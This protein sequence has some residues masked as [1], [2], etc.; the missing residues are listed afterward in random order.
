MNEDEKLLRKANKAWRQIYAIKSIELGFA[1]ASLI[2][3]KEQTGYNYNSSSHD[4]EEK[5]YLVGSELPTNL[6]VF[7]ISNDYSLRQDIRIPVVGRKSP[8]GLKEF[9]GSD[10][11]A[12]GLS[13]GGYYYSNLKERMKVITSST[14]Q[15]PQEWIDGDCDDILFAIKKWN[16]AKITKDILDPIHRHLIPLAT[17]MGLWE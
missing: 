4:F 8:F 15:Y 17:R 9:I 10:Q 2:K 16:K 12:D 13:G 5:M 3:Y 14:Y 11:C 7:A 1:P 6:S